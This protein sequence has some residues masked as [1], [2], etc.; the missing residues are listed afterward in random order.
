MTEPTPE[1]KATPPPEV[2]PETIPAQRPLWRDTRFVTYWSAQSVSELGDRVSELALPLVAISIGA[3]A[4]E[5]ALLTALVWLPNLLA[6]LVGSWVDRQP[7]KRRLLIASD[8]ARALVILTVPATFLVGALTLA[9]LFAVAFLLGAWSM[10]FRS[11]W[12]PFFVTLVRREQY[13]EANSLLSATR[14]GSFIA[15]PAIGG[16]LVQFVTA[17]VTLLI[18]GLSFLLSA[19]LLRRVRVTEPAP[20]PAV[21]GESLKDRLAEGLR[22]VVRHPILRPALGCVS[23]L[24]FFT[25]M[26]SAL[27]IVFASRDLGLAAGAIGVS[28]GVGAS[29]G[30]V[31]A[32]FAGRVARWIGTGRTIALGAV[33]FTTPIAALPLAHGSDLAKAAVLAAVEAVSAFGIMLFDVNLNA[34]QATVIP[35]SVR[36]RVQG[37]FTSINY[38]AR[39]LGAAVGGLLAGILGTGPTLVIAGLG[40]ALSVAW[41]FGT[42]LLTLRSVS[43]LE[44]PNEP[45]GAK[46]GRHG[47]ATSH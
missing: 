37:A 44:N 28:L 29:G 41:L 21:E 42:P 8:L 7:R 34:V 4:T 11:A 12:Q 27:L 40:G 26:G 9:H 36:A 43:D 10:L 33:I 3:N 25:I 5:V 31:G 45:R 18:D 39:P 19:T 15:G 35:D 1:S 17:P 24:N 22:V 23:W 2:T 32:V 20:A 47:G 30:L 14:S 38:G 46:S 6:L 16:G 13:V